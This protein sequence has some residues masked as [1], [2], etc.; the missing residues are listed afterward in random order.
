VWIKQVALVSNVSLI[1]IEMINEGK[2]RLDVVN[3]QGYVISRGDR[4]NPNG[5]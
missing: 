3:E 5:G 1:E 2:F 4:D